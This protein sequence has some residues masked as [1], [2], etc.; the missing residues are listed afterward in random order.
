MCKHGGSK[1]LTATLIFKDI[2]SSILDNIFLPNWKN[3]CTVSS[4]IVKDSRNQGL[5]QNN[6]HSKLP[7]QRTLRYYIHYEIH[8]LLLFHPQLRFLF[9]VSSKYKFC[10]FQK[11][12][13]TLNMHLRIKLKSIISHRKLNF[14]LMQFPFLSLL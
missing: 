12:G 9:F 3:E 4:T 10:F 5:I 11:D 2:T 13:L 14:L 7:I 6:L 1:P 8:I